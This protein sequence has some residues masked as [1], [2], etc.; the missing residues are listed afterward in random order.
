MLGVERVPGEGEGLGERENAVGELHAAI[1]GRGG[2][3]E[4]M[5]AGQEQGGQASFG[6]EEIE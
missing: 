2:P 5:E 4:R 1:K 3:P 6:D